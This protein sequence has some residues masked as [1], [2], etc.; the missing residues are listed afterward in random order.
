MVPAVLGV[1]VCWYTSILAKKLMW[2]IGHFGGICEGQQRTDP[3]GHDGPH[4]SPAD[5]QRRTRPEARGHH[6]AN[7]VQT[8]GDGAV[9]ARNCGG[10]AAVEAWDSRHSL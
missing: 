8:R 3:R 1:L 2:L 9:L 10:R 7:S 4:G 6:R 5:Q